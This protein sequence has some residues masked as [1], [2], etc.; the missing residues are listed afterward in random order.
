MSA[1]TY[2]GVEDEVRSATF[3]RRRRWW[4]ASREEV[5][6]YTDYE[7]DGFIQIWHRERGGIRARLRKEEEEVHAVLE[8]GTEPT[9]CFNDNFVRKRRR[10]TG[11][12]QHRCD[13]C[14]HACT[15]LMD[16]SQ[17]ASE[18]QDRRSTT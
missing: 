5:D 6:D 8:E 17:V 12:T 18:S 2:A 14:M 13:V 4:S 11:N 15:Q 10:R 1:T 3:R 9:R 7:E 16:M